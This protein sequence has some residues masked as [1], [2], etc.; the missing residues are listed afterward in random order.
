MALPRHPEC[1]LFITRP[2]IRGHQRDRAK[3]VAGVA[4]TSSSEW[5]EGPSQGRSSSPQTSAIPWSRLSD[6]RTE[7]VREVEGNG[8]KEQVLGI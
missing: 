4:P 1:F 3:A 8:E 7:D 5:E 6:P 2:R